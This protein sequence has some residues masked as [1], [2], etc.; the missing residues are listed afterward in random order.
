MSD[1]MRTTKPNLKPV[2]PGILLLALLTLLIYHG[3]ILRPG[4]IYGQDTIVQGYP[5][6]WYQAVEGRAFGPGWFPYMMSGFPNVDAP[7]FHLGGW[8]LWLMPVTRSIT[9]R[10][11][12]HT[13]GAA[14]LMFLLMRRFGR[15]NT[16]SIIGGMAFGFSAFF[17]SKVYAGHGAALWSGIWIPLTMLFLDRTIETKRPKYAILTGAIIGLQILGTHPQYVYYTGLA[18][19][20]FAVWRIAPRIIRERQPKQIAIYAGLGMLSV[21]FAVLVSAPYLFSFLQMMGLSNRGGGA[22]YEFASSLSLH[23]GQLLAAAAPSFWGNPTRANSVFGALYWDGAMYIGVIP[24]L[25]ALVAFAGVF[26]DPRASYFKALAVL[27]ILIALGNYTPIFRLIYHIPGFDMVRAPSK[28]LYLYTFAA[29]ALS[30]YG[31]DLLITSAPRLHSRLRIGS[32]DLASNEP[33]SSGRRAERILLYAFIV[34]LALVFVLVVSH[35]PLQSFA[36]KMI[37]ATKQNAPEVAAKL[38]GFLTLQLWSIAWSAAFAGAAAAV[39]A[40]I[41]RR[42]MAIRTAAAMIAA[43][44]FVELWMYAGPLLHITNARE[45]FLSTDRGAFAAL[46]ADNEGRFRILPMDT[47]VYQYAQGIFDGMESVNGY[48]PISL[49]RYAAYVGAMNGEPAYETV[50]ADVRN[51][52]S[53]LLDMLNVK[54]V[55]SSKPLV[56]EKLAQ[57]HAGRTYVFRNTSCLPRTFTVHHAKVVSRPEEALRAIQSPRFDPRQTLIVEKRNPLP[58]SSAVDG[59]DHIQTIH[60]SPNEIHLMVRMASAGYLV[61]SEVNYPGWRAWIDDKPAQ[62]LQANYLFRAVHV[63]KGRHEVRMEFVSTPYRVGAGLSLL[64]LVFIAA[65]FILEWQKSNSETDSLPAHL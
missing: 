33:R 2:L 10:Y 29:A 19:F 43:L 60:Y 34:L 51:Y 15:S 20:L 16:A 53:P 1:P 12:L 44:T 48:Y 24:L 27:S 38:D 18:A 11:I 56:D 28:I 35:R 49:A 46:R 22:G 32:V 31:F 52:R 6:N 36:E 7:P 57:V 62:V 4:V 61:L 30:A 39:T 58:K 65:M 23:P 21:L 5:L 59:N 47:D 17:I 3:V 9:W 41:M 55:L 26:R 25:L 40:L 8:L 37:Y 63:P 45:A 13:F 42:R 50:S 54:Y 14:A 64:S